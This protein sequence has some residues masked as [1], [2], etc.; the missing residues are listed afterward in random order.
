MPTVSS[1]SISSTSTPSYIRVR[2][3]ATALCPTTCTSSPFRTAPIPCPRSCATPIDN[4][5]TDGTFPRSSPL[6]STTS[7]HAPSRARH[8]S[9][10]SPSHHP[11]WQRPPRRFRFR[12]RPSRLPQSPPPVLH[13][14]SVFVGGLLPYVQPPAP[15]RHSAPRRFLARAPAPHPWPLRSLSQCAPGPIRPPLAGPLLLLPARPRAPV[16][17]PPLC[18]AQPR[19]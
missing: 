1:T 14:I 5:V 9:R 18:R 3:W 2:W 17:G 19:T 16:D 4:P 13:P 11:A 8:R 6:P 15:H 12:C 10:C 7:L